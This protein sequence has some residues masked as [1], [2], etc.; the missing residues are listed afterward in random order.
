MPPLLGRRF[1]AHLG[2]V[3]PIRP[4]WSYPLRLHLARSYVKD[5]FALCQT[6]DFVRAFIL[7]RTLTPATPALEPQFG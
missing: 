5:R 6:P 2:E 3:K 7:D 4:R 1:G